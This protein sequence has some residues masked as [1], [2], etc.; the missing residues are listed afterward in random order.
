MTIAIAIHIRYKFSLNLPLMMMALRLFLTV[1]LCDL[2]KNAFREIGSR[3]RI[4]F[5]SI[6]V[7]ESST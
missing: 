2:W 3:S 6:A 7:D 5:H 1:R 4:I